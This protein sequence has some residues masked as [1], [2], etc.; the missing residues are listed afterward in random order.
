MLQ[1]CHVVRRDLMIL[2]KLLIK[3][4]TIYIYIVYAFGITNK[5]DRHHITEILLSGVPKSK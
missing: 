2:F 3:Q 5:T 1:G 4:F